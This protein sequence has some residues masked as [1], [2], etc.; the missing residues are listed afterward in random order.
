[1]FIYRGE[2]EARLKQ[3]K[4]EKRR[5][6]AAI[7]KFENDFQNVTG[8][9]PQKDEKYSSTEM[10]LAYQKYKRTKATARL[11][12]VLISKRKVPSLITDKGKSEN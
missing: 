4:D 9:P 11:L 6:R 2:L 3:A 1:M 5:M 10:E 12:D 7:R 8:R